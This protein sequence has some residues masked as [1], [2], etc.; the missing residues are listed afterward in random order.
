MTASAALHAAEAEKRADNHVTPVKRAGVS[1][2]GS[3]D[4]SR[5]RDKN[6]SGKRTRTF[7]FLDETSSS[8]DSTTAYAKVIEEEMEK[9]KRTDDPKTTTLVP[10]LPTYVTS[11]T[12]CRLY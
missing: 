2:A 7:S 8:D 6:T 5:L 12:T 11:F 3:A 10:K 9:K 4:G 1:P